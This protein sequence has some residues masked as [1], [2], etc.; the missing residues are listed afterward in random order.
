M[1]NKKKVL[2][3][4]PEF[5]GLTETFIER[6]VSKLAESPSLQVEVL[7]LKKG[8]GTLSTN[9]QNITSY[10]ELSWIDIVLSLKYLFIY[11]IRVIKAF[12]IILQNKNR[13]ILENMYLFL[14]SLGYTYVFETHYPDVI[15][16]HFMSEPSTICLIASLI[17][18]KKLGIS[19]HAKD[20]L[21]E[22]G[23]ISE[24]VELIKFKVMYSSFITVC[25]DNAYKKLLKKCEIKYPK[26]IYL[27]YHGIDES[28]LKG[29]VK[30]SISPFVPKKPILFSIGRFVE[31]KG[32]AYLLEAAKILKE[33]DIDFKLYIVGA[34]G[35]LYA[36]ILDM[37]NVLE[38]KDKVEIVGEGNGL[39][40]D[41]ILGYYK[42]ADIFVFPSVNVSK[43][44]ADGI[45]NVLIESAIL[46]IPIITTDA[47]SITDFI[48]DK[49]DGLIVAQRDSRDLAKALE[50]LITHKEL[51]KKLAK[52]A[53]D[54]ALEL[55]NIDTNVKEIEKL[56]LS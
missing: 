33:K 17:L 22:G 46:N 36:G 51:Q 15:Y 19:A 48:E 5:P 4:I 11:P 47:G 37:L 53:H 56:L 34:P 3:F 40:F 13:T 10:I 26:N 8:N 24:N 39:S 42:I 49:K 18:N 7:S 9:S 31:K 45:P 32:F 50:K 25:N 23:P 54:K 14:K 29:Q 52:S 20:V 21:Q 27:K 28:W 12:S 16:S 1:A 2:I 6:E 44:D 35:P 30:D 43:G 38:I 41:E 55:F